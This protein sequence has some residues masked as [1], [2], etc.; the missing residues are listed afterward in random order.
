MTDLEHVKLAQYVESQLGRAFTWGGLD[1]YLFVL[2][3]LDELL[4]SKFADLIAGRYNTEAGARAFLA[5]GE[6]SFAGFLSKLGASEIRRNFERAGDVLLVEA[7]PF[8]GAHICLGAKYASCA[9][10]VGVTVRP[11]AYLLPWC[12]YRVTPS[13]ARLL[14]A[15]TW[16]RLSLR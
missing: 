15:G 6:L 12:G 14:E 13:T 8:V 4:G 7:E 1:C 3:W 10:E 5:A 9:P 11:L 16:L 2:R